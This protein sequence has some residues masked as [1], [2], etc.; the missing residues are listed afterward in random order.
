MKYILGCEGAGEEG[1]EQDDGLVQVPDE[2]A[3]NLPANVVLSFQFL[4]VST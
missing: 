2:H 3:L 4:K 1:V